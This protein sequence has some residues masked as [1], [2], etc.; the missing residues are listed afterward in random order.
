MKT[1]KRFERP[2]L[3][4]GGMGRELRFRGVEISPTIWSA[5]ALLTAPQVVREIH[6]DFI[7][8]GA[9]L[10]TT[11]TYGVIRS[12]LGREGIEHRF[13]ELNQLACTLACEARDACGG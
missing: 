10:I 1:L 9:D 11:N 12:D 6:I 4:D 2:I 5:Q 7:R 8:A 13:E 3:M